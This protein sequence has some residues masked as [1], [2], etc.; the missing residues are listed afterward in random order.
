[1]NRCPTMGCGMRYNMLHGALSCHFIIRINAMAVYLT[2]R[3][4]LRAQ[5][6]PAALTCAAMF[7]KWSSETRAQRLAP[8]GR[9]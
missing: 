2:F 1:M 6:R 4:Y 5:A 3:A 7:H 8:Y 9:C